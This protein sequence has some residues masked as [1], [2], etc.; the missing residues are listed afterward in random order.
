MDTEIKKDV[1][2]SWELFEK[3]GMVGA[4]LVHQETQKNIALL[5]KAKARVFEDFKEDL[6]EK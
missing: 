5:E 4:F 2:F 6:E 1:D 3:T